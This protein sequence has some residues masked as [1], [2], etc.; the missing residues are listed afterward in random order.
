MGSLLVHDQ[1]RL[2]SIDVRY[3]MRLAKVPLLLNASMRKRLLDQERILLIQL[4]ILPLVRDVAQRRQFV[5][6][7]PVLSLEVQR[8]DV[9]QRQ[10]PIVQST[11]DYHMIINYAGDMVPPR[12]RKV[13]M[14][15]LLPMLCVQVLLLDIGEVDSFVNSFINVEEADVAYAVA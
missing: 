14:K 13:Q 12:H 2:G 10:L 5:Y 11:V 6:R 4:D 8:G 7:R 3:R 15:M 9:V 1:A